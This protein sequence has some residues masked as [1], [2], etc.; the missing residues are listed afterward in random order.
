MK[1]R[2]I[3]VG[4][5]GVA[6]IPLTA[7][8]QQTKPVIGF[9]HSGSRAPA[10]D[11]FQQGLREAG[12]VEGRDV[13]IERRY[14]EGQYDRLRELAT[15]LV[16]WPAAVISAAGGAHTAIA[17]KTATTS[18]PIVF[19]IGSDPVKFG[20]VPSLNRPGGNVTGVS[21]FAAE[22]EPKRLGL[23][24]GVV[25]HAAAIGGLI[26]PNNANAQ[27]QARDLI[28]AARALGT[29]M[30]ILHAGTDRE[31]ETAFARL[32]ELAGSAM[33]VCSDP[34]VSG[35]RDLAVGLAA[36]HA[37]PA[38]YEWREFAEQ[39]GLMS[40]GT[41]LADTYRQS[42]LYTGRILRGENPAEMPVTRAIK[43]EFV[44]N[45][46]TAKALGLTV[47]NAMQLLAD[48]VIE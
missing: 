18:T 46:K 43:F 31:L 13:I 23:L 19:S 6:A 48:E 39:G 36:R 12:F 15:E 14:A 40:Y 2:D 22:L 26:N 44:I 38:I 33:V 10:H 42:G 4:L 17:A 3:I 29:Q 30:H 28:E 20:L 34:F 27:N 37:I 9:L 45:L 47:P 11:G 32:V 35:R 25:P 21:F 16:R 7:R 24:H 8:A 41:N 1:R 5:A